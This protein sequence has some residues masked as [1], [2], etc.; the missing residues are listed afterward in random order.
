MEGGSKKE[1]KEVKREKG[2]KEVVCRI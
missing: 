1:E 2:K